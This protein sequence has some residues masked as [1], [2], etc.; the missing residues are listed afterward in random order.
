MVL[1]ILIKNWIKKNRK[2]EI[3]YWLNCEAVEKFKRTIS[4]K[5]LDKPVLTVWS[6]VNDF[7][8]CVMPKSENRAE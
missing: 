1:I 5:A 6:E 3:E 7:I 2:I 4:E 8:G